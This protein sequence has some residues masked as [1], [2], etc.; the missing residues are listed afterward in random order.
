MQTAEV[1]QQASICARDIHAQQDE[2]KPN[3]KQKTYAERAT[4]H[5]TKFKMYKS[6]HTIHKEV[7]YSHSVSIFKCLCCN[8]QKVI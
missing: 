7:S 8:W 5:Q 3:P 4:N 6:A 1:L 2:L